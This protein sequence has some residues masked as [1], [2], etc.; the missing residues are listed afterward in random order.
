MSRVGKQTKKP[1]RLRSRSDASES[2]AQALRI[3]WIT[4]SFFP[5]L[6]GLEVFIEK[7]VESLGI[8]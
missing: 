4:T 5:K 1:R 8:L 2:G 7:T 3:L 6:G